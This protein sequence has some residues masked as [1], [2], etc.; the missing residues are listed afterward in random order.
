SIRAPFTR[1]ASSASRFRFVA[2]ARPRQDTCRRNAR[3]YK[4]VVIHLPDYQKDILSV[5]A[6]KEGHHG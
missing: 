1:R 2:I 3:G 5:M 4:T 6:Y